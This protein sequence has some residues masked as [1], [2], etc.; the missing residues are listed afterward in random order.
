MLLPATA[1]AALSDSL[2]FEDF[3][4]EA[5]VGNDNKW[6]VTETI[7]VRFLS[8][9]HGIYLY[10]DEHFSLVRGEKDEDGEMQRKEYDFYCRL[11]NVE[12]EG[13]PFTVEED[14]TLQL[15]RIGDADRMVDGEQT[16]TVGYTYQY[17]DDR[18][19]E[20]D[21][22]FHSLLGPGYQVPI[23]HFSFRIKTEK[24]V[25]KEWQKLL[26][27]Y[28][29]NYGDTDNA[30]GISVR[31]EHGAICGEATDLQPRQAV[32]I[33]QKLPEGFFSDVEKA[34]DSKMQW[35]FYLTVVLMLATIVVA[36][37]IRHQRVVKQIEFYPPEGISSAEVGVIIDESVDNVDMVSL[38]PWLAHHGY[39]SLQELKKPKTLELTQLKELPDDAPQY[40]KEYVK[41]IFGKKSQVRLSDLDEK[42]LKGMEKARM[43]LAKVFQG[44]KKLTRVSGYI[45]LPWLL[46]PAVAAVVFLSDPHE[47]AKADALGL[48]LLAVVPIFIVMIVRLILSGGDLIRSAKGRFWEVA[49]G[50]VVMG[51][52]CFGG[53]YL[54]N[55]YPTES[56]LA[57]WHLAVL[58][59]G[60]FVAAE[61]MGRFCVNTDYRVKM[62]GKLLGLREFIQTAEKD[63]LCQLMDDDPKYF[64]SILPYAQV[65]GISDK[66]VN[67]FDGIEV[68]QPE[69]YV[70]THRLATGAL[71]HNLT[72]QISEASS[73]VMATVNAQASSSSTGHISGGFAGGGG[74]GGGGGGW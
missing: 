63:R 48:A 33:Y 15:I 66:W 14:G 22:I 16:Y 36:L 4:V 38:I 52:F 65:F 61:M 69:W 1:L 59:A 43:A 58:Y 42:S 51:L 60:S 55:Q 26:S 68:Q 71:L 29:G 3:H 13:W 72:T 31:Y 67:L 20:R 27:V 49:F 21:Y 53:L 57:P 18:C 2:Y 70:S 24:P 34:T 6:T 35:A 44:D 54:I 32:T 7:S 46:L 19:G 5:L 40:Q 62:M 39:I 23:R 56:F 28:S 41:A 74:G 9:H 37:R 12:V 50:C 47:F 73:N 17:P 25:P 11:D 10:R 30:A 45:A 64:F 8:P